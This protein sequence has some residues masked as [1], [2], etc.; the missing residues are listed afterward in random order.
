M[1]FTDIYVGWPG[2]VH[3]ARVYANSKINLRSAELF[4]IQ[5]HLIGD[6]AYPLSKTMLTPYRDNGHLSLQQRNYNKKHSSTR[7]VVERAFG[8]LK[9]KWRRLHHLEMSSVDS[10]CQVIAASCVLHNFVL[11]EDGP[12][13]IPE[14]EEDGVDDNNGLADD[15]NSTGH[16]KR[17]YIAGLLV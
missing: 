13:D 1:G 15:I 4:P 16:N 5:G 6:G 2:S 14:A 9:V 8:L 17:D 10:M 12:E 3:D 7:V 11:V